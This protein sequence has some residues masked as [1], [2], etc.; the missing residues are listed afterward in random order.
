M[1][2]N[3]V[4]PSNLFNG[5]SSYYIPSSNT[6]EVNDG[7]DEIPTTMPTLKF[8]RLNHN[9]S[10]VRRHGRGFLLMAAD[11]VMIPALGRVQVP[12]NVQIKLPSLQHY[13]LIV[14][15]DADEF[16]LSPFLSGLFVPSSV[17]EPG[18]INKPVAITVL[19]MSMT[20]K[21]INIGEPIAKL[22]IEKSE[23]VYVVGTPRINEMTV[24]LVTLANQH[25]PPPPAPHVITNS[26]LSPPLYLSN[27]S[28]LPPPPY[29]P[30]P[31]YFPPPPYL[32]PSSNLSSQSNPSIPSVVSSEISTSSKNP[33]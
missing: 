6:T 30:P 28:Y 13:G 31:S 3:L 9:A 26:F 12:T 25:S 10:T 14:N 29:L 24:T 1:N 15:L 11:V 4:N 33:K 32:E 17:I 2:N 8:V 20:S 5:I 21:R 19:N 23:K 27:P 16:S 18:D 7:N 22:M